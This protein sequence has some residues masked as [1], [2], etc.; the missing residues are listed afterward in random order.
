MWLRPADALS[1]ERQLKLM[2]VTEETLRT[3]G[4]FARAADA[5]AFAATPREVPLIMPRIG[6]MRMA[7]V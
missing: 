3:L 1:Q 4:T 5:I 2:L 7:V 6:R